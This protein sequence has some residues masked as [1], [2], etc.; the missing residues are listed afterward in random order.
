MTTCTLIASLPLG[1]QGAT[2]DVAE[3]YQTIPLHPSQWPSVVVRIDDD[4]PTFAVDTALCFGYGPSA[5]VYGEL[6]DAGLDIMRAQGISP[7]ITW[8]DDHLF[9]HLPRN[10]IRAYNSWRTHTA[11]IITQNGGWTHERCR[12]WFKGRE[13]AD[14]THKEFAEDCARP[15]RDFPH[16]EEPV[17]DPDDDQYAYNFSDI[18]SIS[19][20]LGIPWEASKDAP[21]SS[22]PVYFGFEWDLQCKTVCLT[23]HKQQKYTTAIHLWLQSPCHPLS[24]VEKLYGKLSHAALVIPEGSAYLM[25]LQTMLGM[26]GDRPFMPRTQPRETTKDLDWWLRTL[27]NPTHL[28]IPHTPTSLNLNAFS[29]ACTSFGIAI[30]IAGRWHAWCLLPGWDSDNQ[31]IGWVESIGFEFL[32]RTLL[33]L[34]SSTTPLMVYGDNQGVIEAWQ[35]GRSRNKPTNTTFKWIHASLRSP[36]RHVFAKYVP[37]GHNPADGPSHGLYLTSHISLPWFPIPPDIKHFICDYNDT[38]HLPLSI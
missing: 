35:A 19:Y 1:T 37:S 11:D 7:I 26:F 33:I 38:K 4:P 29:D 32:I 20:Q 16:P 12:I 21:F 3:A 6:R 30:T 22:K 15:L 17:A 31:D 24:D 36:P 8:V 28:P 34:D 13:L 2:R 9:F 27:E 18:N 25:S 23:E 10:S 5:S 14:G